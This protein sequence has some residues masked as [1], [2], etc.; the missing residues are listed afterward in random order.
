MVVNVPNTTVSAILQISKIM[1][2]IG[3]NEEIS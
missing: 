1:S 2:G 3:K